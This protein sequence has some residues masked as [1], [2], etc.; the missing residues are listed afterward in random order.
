[1]GDAGIGR[2]CLQR[3]GPLVEGRRPAAT[4]GRRAV[5]YNE[6]DPIAHFLLGN[7]NRD[8][9]NQYQTCDYLRASARSYTRMLEINEH[10]A[11]AQNARS[12][13]EQIT[14]IARQ[15]GC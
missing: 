11:E 3:A 14:G 7:V 12:Y 8:L 9:F 13:R 1:M 10:I 4:G 5:D 15:L 2:Q 6:H